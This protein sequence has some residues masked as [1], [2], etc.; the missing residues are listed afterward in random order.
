VMYEPAAM[1]G[2]PIME[3]LLQRT[4]LPLAAPRSGHNGTAA[5]CTT[6]SL[7]KRADD[8]QRRDGSWE[9]TQSENV[10]TLFPQAWVRLVIKVRR[11]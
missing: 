10:A 5:A 7:S 1:G 3:G 8:R 4:L 6:S 11:V 2:P 9:R